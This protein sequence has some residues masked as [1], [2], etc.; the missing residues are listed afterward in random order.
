[1][2]D[3]SAAYLSLAK[4]ANSPYY[5]KRTKNGVSL[6]SLQLEK[7][8]LRGIESVSEYM[9]VERIFRKAYARVFQF[10]NDNSEVTEYLMANKGL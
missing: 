7:N 5:L 2:N 10:I 9:P 6:L 4:L 8:M 3:L 1:M